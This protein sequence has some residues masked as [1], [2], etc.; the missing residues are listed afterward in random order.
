[1]ADRAQSLAGPD[2]PNVRKPPGHRH[3]LNGSTVPCWVDQGKNGI[4]LLVS[5]GGGGKGWPPFEGEPGG[6]GKNGLSCSGR[7][8]ETP[9]A[10]GGRGKWSSN[11][12]FV[13]GSNSLTFK[14]LMEPHFQKRMYAHLRLI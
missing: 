1:M 13:S 9:T 8:S 4:S 14:N 10:M 2:Q 5:L 12:V 7:S 11:F 3:H 6:D